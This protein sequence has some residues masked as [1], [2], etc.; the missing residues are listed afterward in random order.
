MPAKKS[1]LP[2][3]MAAATGRVSAG[4]I[5][6]VEL[7]GE[8]EEIAVFQ[9]IM[10]DG[11]GVGHHVEQLVRIESGGGSGGDVADVVGTRAL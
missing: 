7:A 11:A 5:S 10:M 4:V 2:T 8:S 1:R 6:D 3:V 9:D